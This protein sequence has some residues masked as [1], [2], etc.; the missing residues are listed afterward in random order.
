MINDVSGVIV[1]LAILVTIKLGWSLRVI[2]LPLRIT[3]QRAMVALVLSAVL[4]A[5]GWVNQ[6]TIMMLGSELLVLTGTATIFSVIRQHIKS[7]EHSA[8]WTGRLIALWLT[9]LSVLVLFVIHVII[10]V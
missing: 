10:V 8:H 2:P 9:W 7:P 1:G 3:W 5:I 6:H 4:A